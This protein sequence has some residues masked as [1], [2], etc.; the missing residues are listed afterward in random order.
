MNSDNPS[1]QAPDPLRPA[2][3][4]ATLVYALQALAVPLPVTL[5]VGVIINYVKRGSA[6]GTWID[7]H[8]Q[9]QI[10]TFWGF[11][12]WV[13]AVALAA[14]LN[15]GTLVAVLAVI[16]LI[17]RFAKGWLRLRAG[18][19]MTSALTHVVRGDFQ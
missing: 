19:P 6:A 18:E 1:D 17:Y 14:P 5:L 9:W 15:L 4:A 11:V 12:L 2:R 8:F 3:N 13:A 10:N 16:W 7:S